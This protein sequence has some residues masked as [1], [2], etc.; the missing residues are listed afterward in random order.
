L[1]ICRNFHKLPA[2]KRI[3]NT[4]Y[5]TFTRKLRIAKLSET[6]PRYAIFE[7]FHDADHRPLTISDIEK[8]LK[9]PI[10]RSTIYRTLDTFEDNQIIKRVYSGWKFK[11]ELSDDFHGFHHHLICVS[12]NTT[13]R[14]PD[15]KELDSIVSKLGQLYGYNFNDHQLD[16]RGICANCMRSSKN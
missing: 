12:C 2:M 4:Q 8:R 7:I 1:Q 9:I 15:Q 13:V 11:Y 16:I 5:W 14:L 6:K 3:N 10:D